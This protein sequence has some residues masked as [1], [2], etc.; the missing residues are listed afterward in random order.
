MASNMTANVVIKDVGTFYGVTRFDIAKGQQFRVELVNAPGPVRWFAEHDQVLEYQEATDMMSAEMSAKSVGQS[1]VQM[2][3]PADDKILEL[4]ITVF[5][6][7]A[8]KLVVD[9][10][11]NEPLVN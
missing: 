11:V 8:E 9:S 7:E 5:G 6:T 2:R 3:G 4:T 1:L 10:V